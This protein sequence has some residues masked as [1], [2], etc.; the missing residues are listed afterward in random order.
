MLFTLARF[1]L[2]P[3]EWID[4]NEWRKLEEFERGSLAFMWMETG[5]GM[6]I[7]Y[8]ALKRLNRAEW[9]DAL[10]WLDALR[11]WSKNYE[12]NNMVPAKENH[13][14]SESLVKYRQ[15]SLPSWVEPYVEKLF[16][17]V[18]DDR[19]REALMCVT[20]LYSFRSIGPRRLLLIT[21]RIQV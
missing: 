16:M 12:A 6:G 18:L 2:E 20:P 9:R 7:S 15:E 4:K 8:D 5:L 13:S 19:L 3:I 11:T 1:V 21:H 14:I 10:D 17:A